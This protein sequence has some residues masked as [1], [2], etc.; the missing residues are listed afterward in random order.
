MDT[1]EKLA[2]LLRGE[3]YIPYGHKA[4]FC[5]AQSIIHTWKLGSVKR[6]Q[7]FPLLF[8]Q[9]AQIS[10][11]FINTCNMEQL[12]V[13]ELPLERDRETGDLLT[14]HP[15]HHA[16][17]A[18]HQLAAQLR[19]NFR[20]ISDT[21]ERS[22]ILGLWPHYGPQPEHMVTNSAGCSLPSQSLLS[23]FCL[24]NWL[25]IQWVTQLPRAAAPAL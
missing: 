21:R 6:K 8:F 17:P 4:M 9:L 7:N 25:L 23:P 15:R 10:P 12:W 24:N 13:K 16:K 5:F 14:D 1:K 20:E 3:Q 19:H 11:G 22:S 18:H 2:L